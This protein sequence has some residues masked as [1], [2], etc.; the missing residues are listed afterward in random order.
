[1]STQVNQYFMYGIH[2]PYDW[3][4]EWEGKTGKDFHNTFEE[5]MK[6][7]AFNTN[8]SHKDGIF[9]LFD[10]RDGRF[11]I[12]G[13]VLA[14]TTDEDPFIASDEPYKVPQLLPIEEDGI[15]ARVKKYFGLEGEFN[16]YF[17]T[18]YR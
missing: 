18:R 4:K 13:R 11:I 5:F 3:H 7:N 2:M 1:M 15:K 8:I 16:Y 17:I 14:K 12:I 10:G 9:C 6:D